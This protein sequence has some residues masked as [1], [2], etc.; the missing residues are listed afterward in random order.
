MAEDAEH[1]LV[2]PIE[3]PENK[4]NENDKVMSQ[5][6]RSKLMVPGSSD[7]LMQSNPEE[8]SVVDKL[9]SKEKDKGTIYSHDSNTTKG[10][11]AELETTIRLHGLLNTMAKQN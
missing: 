2:S 1:T 5:E 4:V 7:F 9:A 6:K 8:K 11:Q 10:L 3:V